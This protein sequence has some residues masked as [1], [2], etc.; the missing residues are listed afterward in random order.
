MCFVFSVPAAFARLDDVVVGRGGR[1][2]G[3]VCV[4][5]TICRG[6]GARE[7]VWEREER[8]DQFIG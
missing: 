7:E 1:G 4:S 2:G 8:R 3:Y 5:G 6:R